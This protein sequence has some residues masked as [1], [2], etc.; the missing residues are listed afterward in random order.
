ME[1]EGKAKQVEAA[2]MQTAEDLKD[3]AKGVLDSIK[4]KIG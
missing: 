1:V 3:K 4:E 2:A